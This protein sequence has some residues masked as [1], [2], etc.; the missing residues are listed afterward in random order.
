MQIAQEVIQE[1]LTVSAHARQPQSHRIFVAFDVARGGSNGSP[2]GQLT[3]P[4]P[5]ETLRRPNA[6]IGASRARG[7][8][9][10]TFPTLQPL[11][12][13]MPAPSNEPSFR[14]TQTIAETIPIS[15][16]ASCQIHSRSSLIE[17][18]SRKLQ[19]D[20][21]CKSLISLSP[22]Y[23]DTTQNSTYKAFIQVYGKSPHP[24]V[25]PIA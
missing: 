15:T 21:S 24:I 20:K 4:I 5:K 2:L 12:P 9:M 23:R 17:S 6:C 25:A 13:A 16:V 11:C 18:S 3:N 7:K 19:S 14:T 8:P 10:P 1:P 22:R